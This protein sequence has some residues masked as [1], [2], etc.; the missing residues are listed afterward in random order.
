MFLV[1]HRI[2]VSSYLSAK[3]LVSDYYVPES[4]KIIRHG[5]CFDRGLVGVGGGKTVT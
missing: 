5:F 3:Y 2:K 1:V 4:T